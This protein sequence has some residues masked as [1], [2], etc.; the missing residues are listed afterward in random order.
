MKSCR[1]YAQLLRTLSID[2][3][4][5]SKNDLYFPLSVYSKAY[6][7][8][9]MQMCISSSIISC[10]DGRYIFELVEQVESFFWSHFLSVFLIF[11]SIDTF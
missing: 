8:N 9:S 2:G 4:G 6:F 3:E 1:G 5:R 11:P 7:F 10:S